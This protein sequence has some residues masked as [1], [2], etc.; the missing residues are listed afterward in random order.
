MESQSQEP[1]GIGSQPRRHEERE[2]ERG[3]CRQAGESRTQTHTAHAQEKGVQADLLR[4]SSLTNYYW[5]T[6][7]LSLDAALVPALFA[8]LTRT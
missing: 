5:T 7:I 4:E 2:D 6:M 1:A 3:R 8:A